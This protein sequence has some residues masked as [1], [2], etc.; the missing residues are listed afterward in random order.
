VAGVLRED[1]QELISEYFTAEVSLSLQWAVCHC[2]VKHS[3]H[4]WNLS[5]SVQS[6]GGECEKQRRAAGP[7]CSYSWVFAARTIA[8]G[9]HISVSISTPLQERKGPHKETA[10]VHRFVGHVASAGTTQPLLHR[11]T[12]LIIIATVPRMSVMIGEIPLPSGSE[13]LVMPWSAR[14]INQDIRFRF[15]DANDHW[16]RFLA[17]K[18]G[19]LSLEQVLFWPRK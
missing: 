17:T 11:R 18:H 9:L 16:D 10:T 7:E 2:I 5:V 8:P 13:V 4:S 1:D 19:F 3:L 6:R 15:V 12:C 14:G